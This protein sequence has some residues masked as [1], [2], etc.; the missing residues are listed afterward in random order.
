[1]KNLIIVGCGAHAAEIVDYIEY[2]NQH[3]TSDTFKIKGLIDNVKT[4]YDHYGYHYDYLGTIDDHT[5]EPDIYYVMGIGNL[6][7]RLKVFQEY[8][9]KKA[10][11]I[12]IIHPTALISKSAIIGEGTV[13]SHNVSIG[14][15]VEIGAF[16][17][18]NSRCTIGHDAKIGNNNFISPQVVLGG[19]SEIGDN[20]L[21]GTNSC[22]IP[23]IK[24]GNDNKIMAGMSLTQNVHD[25]ETVFYR[26]KEKLVV[27]KEFIDQPTNE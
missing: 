26:Y 22:L 20:N 7:I 12:G 3:S 4:H 25:H 17:V 10:Q 5:I 14:P 15:K 8:K 21:L 11:F 27:R 9:L 2:I 18:I 1:M 6:T 13:I 23:E 19:Y 16:N 24:V